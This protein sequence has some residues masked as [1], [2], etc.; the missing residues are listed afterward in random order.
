V[1]R[2][3]I[4]VSVFVVY[5]AK[6][7]HEHPEC[8][9]QL[10]TGG[11]EYAEV[12]VQEVRR[13]CPFFPAVAAR[14]R[15]DFEWSGYHFPKDTRVIFGL[16]ATNHDPKLWDSPHEFRPERFRNWT[17]DPFSFVPQGGGD[18]ELGHRCPG[19]RFSVEITKAAVKFLSEE[20]RYEVPPQDLSLEM[21]HMPALPRSR[22]VI[23]NVR[24]AS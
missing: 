5:A 24:L 7:L 12:F 23:C 3:T 6:M 11:D 17:Y 21:S 4:A 22:F 9:E 13:T 10:V 8:R 19:D 16:Y 14:V 1:L 20:I 18:R 15:H 2:P